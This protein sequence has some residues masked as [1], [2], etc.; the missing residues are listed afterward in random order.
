MWCEKC[1]KVTPHD[2]C[3][4]C[5]QKTEP[6]VPQD[7]FWCKHCNSPILRDLSEPQR[8]ICPHCHSKMK[9]LSSDL[10]PVFPE[11][12]LLLEILTAKPFE[13]ANSSVWANNS[14]YYIDGKAISISSD[15]YSIQNVDHI[16]EQ[17]NKYQ[18]DN[19]S[20]YYEA[21][22][23]HISR[24]VELNRTRLNLIENEAFDFIIKAAQKYSTEQLMISF[25]GGKDSTCTED[26]TVR[27][28]SNPSIVHVFGNTTLEFPLTI[29]YVERFRQNNTK[30]IFKVAKNNEQEFLDVCEDI[31]P[32]SRVMRW[33]CT[34]FKTG[35]ITRVI[36]R[37]Y[38]KGKILTFYGVRKYESTSRSK[39]N[40]LEEHS[41]SV[42]IQKQS[43]ASPI[44]Y[45][46]DVEVWLYILGNKVDF[47][48]AYRLGYD[49]VG[50]WCCPNNNTRAQFLSRIFMPEQSKVWRDFL[51]K[52]AKR[53]GK[54]D[55]EVYVDTQ[56]WKA[57]QGGSGVAAAE[58]VKIK[59]TNCTSETHAKIYEL[60]KP[61]DDSFLNL[62]V[63]IG[64]VSKDLGRKLIH[65]VIVLDP[66]TNIP[67]V[68]I[69][70][71]KSPTSEYA[72]KIKTMNV[73]DH[74]ELQ[75]MASYQVRK[76]NACR[77]CLKC[78]SVCKYGAITIIAGNYKINEAKCKRCKACVTAKYLEG[79]CLMDKYLKTIKFEQK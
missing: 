77:R 27:A 31:G 26:L 21:F 24:F 60:N 65:E 38:G 74:T 48:D 64:K 67:I 16:I 58:D 15:T 13:Y 20:R 17:L 36:N 4:V 8:D 54:P 73:E 62:F 1:Q 47:N 43:V 71:F 6:I 40:R 2:N 57:R 76:F 35:P 42:K 30:V 51:I 34:M 7:I 3:E 70:P 12:R 49:R 46:K 52:F 33:C 29:K 66:K 55:P 61:I 63:P 18:K 78:E 59:Y 41:E 23:Q 32:P 9:H 11:E 28:L 25:S 50:C 69:Q 53:I 10:R 22:N 37:V 39:Y 56:K 44:F 68:S 79:G 72:V 14:R 45:W 19:I 75:R 5:G